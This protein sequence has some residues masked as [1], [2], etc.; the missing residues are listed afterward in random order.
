MVE[1]REKE[2]KEFKEFDMG[3]GG[4]LLYRKEYEVLN[5]ILY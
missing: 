4:V 1:V 5:E 3:L 2:G